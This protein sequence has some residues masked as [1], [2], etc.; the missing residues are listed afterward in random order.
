MALWPPSG[1]G[2]GLRWVFRTHSSSSP[3]QAAI[4]PRGRGAQDRRDLP[5]QG[6]VTSSAH[7][8]KEPA[9]PR[10]SCTRH[11]LRHL[12]LSSRPCHL[13]TSAPPPCPFPLCLWLGAETKVA[14]QGWWFACL[15]KLGRYTRSRSRGSANRAN[16]FRKRRAREEEGAGERREGSSV[17]QK[18]SPQTFAQHFCWGERSL[19]RQS[20]REARLKARSCQETERMPIGEGDRHERPLEPFLGANPFF[21]RFLYPWE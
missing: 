12:L 3:L 8:P 18:K 4:A 15:L 7:P 5:P 11:L 10:P 9:G 14:D 20:G 2:W 6:I 13:H 1:W 19:R 17:Y 21:V 16:P